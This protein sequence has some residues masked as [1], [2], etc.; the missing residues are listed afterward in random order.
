MEEPG[1]LEAAPETAE[2]LPGVP[3]LADLLF[4]AGTAQSSGAPPPPRRR[5][6]EPPAGEELSFG[7]RLRKEFDEMTREVQDAAVWRHETWAPFFS[8]AAW[9]RHFAQEAREAVDAKA[10]DDHVSFGAELRRAE[11]VVRTHSGPGLTKQDLERCAGV[12]IIGL[13]S[14]TLGVAVEVGHGVVVPRVDGRWG[15]P[16]AVGS[17]ATLFGP[18]V[19]VVMSTRC[20]TL[21]KEQV[22]GLRTGADVR[23]DVRANAQV[24]EVG[25]GAYTEYSLQG[26]RHNINQGEVIES[27]TP[28]VQMTGASGQ[29]V[30]LEALVGGTMLFPAKSQST[31]TYY[32][33]VAADERLALPEVRALH[34]ALDERMRGGEPAEAGEDD[35]DDDHAAAE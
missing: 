25:K 3:R 8:G 5:A 28:N 7:D 24:A 11:R 1:A 10:W 15:K 21:T 32:G 14:V 6:E 30:I 18:S 2:F 34:D 31:R 26:I 33:A 23:I 29:G 12:L 20:E 4:G 9:E 17:L 19:G 13:H 27:A 16:L 22:E 35:D